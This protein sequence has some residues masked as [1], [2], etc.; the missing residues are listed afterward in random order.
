MVAPAFYEKLVSKELIAGSGCGK[1]KKKNDPE[2]PA[3]TTEVREANIR[4]ALD[5]T[6]CNVI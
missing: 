2:T 1:K 3:P 6:Y 5:K 4:I